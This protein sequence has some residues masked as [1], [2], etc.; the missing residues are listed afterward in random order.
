MK[1]FVLFLALA[2]S[3]YSCGIFKHTPPEEHVT[4]IHYVD[5][6]RWHDTTVFKEIPV[7]KIVNIIPVG[8]SSHLETSLATSD[9]WA[10]TI[11]LHHT[12]KNK[13]GVIPIKVQWKERIVYKDSIKIEEKPVPYEV[14]KEVIP[15]SYWY[16][17]GFAVLFVA[18]WIVR[19]VLKLCKK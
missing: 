12:L 14:V 19:L 7:E 5:S 2:L 17:L 3:V 18:Y 10:D 1:K 6:T 11:G 16:L 9:A 13:D 8:D 4:I 15:K